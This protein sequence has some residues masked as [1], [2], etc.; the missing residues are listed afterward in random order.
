[1]IVWCRKCDKPV[2]SFLST[3]K[4][5]PVGA[6]T[7]VANCHGERVRRKNLSAEEVHRKVEAGEHI[8]VFRASK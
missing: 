1:M 3:Y 7:V 5:S 8:E 4:R 2:D 6:V